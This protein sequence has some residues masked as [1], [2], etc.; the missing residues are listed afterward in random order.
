MI[1]DDDVIDD[2]IGG[3][4]R[5]GPNTENNQLEFWDKNVLTRVKPMDF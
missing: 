5:S 1:Y 3:H 2:V 4:K